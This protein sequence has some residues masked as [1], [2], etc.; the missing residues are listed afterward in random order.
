[1]KPI[2]FGENEKIPDLCQDAVFKAVLTKDTPPSRAAR[3]KLLSAVINEPVHVLS[4]NA[5]EAPIRGLG[6]R[7]IR[8]D[9]NLILAGGELANVEITKDPNPYEVLRMEYYLAELYTGQEIHGNDLSYQDLKKTWQISFL[10]NRNLFSDKSLIHR[11]TYYDQEHGVELGGRTEIITVELKKVD[12]AVE[13]GIAGMS[14]AELWAY[15]FRYGAD[16]SKRRQINEILAMEE[17]IAMAGQVVQGFTK[18]QLALFRQISK[19]KWETDMRSQLVYEREEARKAGR[20]EGME[21][22]RAEGM[23]AGRAEGM[24]AGRTEGMEAGR[25]K[26]VKMLRKHGMAPEQIAET[27]E[28]PPDVVLAYLKTE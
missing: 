20:V 1:M 11:F 21:A 12:E 2:Q 17:G 26:A 3:D 7:Q 4:I 19:E 15:F 6:D 25:A 23:E 13:R 18:R 24:E 27:L 10:A 22:G 16:R 5:N 8:F 9:M 14:L 28:L